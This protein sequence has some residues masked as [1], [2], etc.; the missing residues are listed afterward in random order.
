MEGLNVVLEGPRN[1]NKADHVYRKHAPGKDGGSERLAVGNKVF[2]PLTSGPGF[3]AT[4]I[5]AVMSNAG[6]KSGAAH[7]LTS[8]ASGS[9]SQLS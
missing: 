7:V 5:L 8:A 6:S 9:K 4:S 2:G 3:L 1:L